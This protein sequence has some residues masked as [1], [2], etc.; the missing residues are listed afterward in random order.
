MCV[1]RGLGQR[2]GADPA[3]AAL[4]DPKATLYSWP[5]LFSVRS[6]AHTLALVLRASASPTDHELFSLL[7]PVVHVIQVDLP[8]GG[9]NGPAHSHL[10]GLLQYSSSITWLPVHMHLLDVLLLLAPFAYIPV[11]A[12][13]VRLLG[14]LLTAAPAG[15]ARD[16]GSVNSLAPHSLRMAPHALAGEPCTPL[17]N[18]SNISNNNSADAS[19][20]GAGRSVTTC[21]TRYWALCCVTRP[22]VPATRR[23]LSGRCP[24]PGSCGKGPPLSF[25]VAVAE[26]RLRSP[27]PATCAATRRRSRPAASRTCAAYWRTTAATCCSCAPKCSS[28]PS[29]ALQVTAVWKGRPHWSQQSRDAV[30]ASLMRAKQP[31]PLETHVATKGLPEDAILALQREHKQQDLGV[32]MGVF[33]EGADDDDDGDDGVDELQQHGAEDGDDDDDEE[34]VPEEDEHEEEAPSSS[35]SKRHKPRARVPAAAAAPVGDARDSVTPFQMWG[36]D[37]DEDDE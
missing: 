29:R 17:A 28:P 26:Q 7:Y 22:P 16:K 30:A 34:E 36:S 2:C 4:A 32:D 12:H 11:A 21:W 8:G 33:R 10:Q 3:P 37:D 14:A 9:G 31:T 24:S 20:Q 13:A 23:S 5:L 6:T 25:G 35:S 1:S 18:S 15:P 27:S 19:W